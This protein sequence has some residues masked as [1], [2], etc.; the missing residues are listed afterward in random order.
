MPDVRN[1]K[2]CNRIYNYI[3]GAQICPSCKDLDEI[4]FKRI[5][6]Y[7][8]ENSGAS[9]SEVSTVLDISVEKIKGFLKDGRLEIVGNE[10]N[11]ALQCESC[12]TAIKTGRL[13]NEC[14]KELQREFKITA[15]QMGKSISDAE[16]TK[17]AVGMRYLNKD[18]RGIQ[19][20]N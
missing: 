2:R 7:L 10:G 17:K 18:D 15:R 13:C 3:G 8:Y 4:D 11:M 5:K 14:A 16:N 20:N 6:E 12:G 19:R 1:C 9:L